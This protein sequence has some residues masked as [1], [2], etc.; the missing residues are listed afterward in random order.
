MPIN[1]QPDVIKKA[2]AAG[3][4][5][6]SEKPVAK[7][8]AT[9]KELIAWYRGL[10]NPPIWAVA[11]NFRYTESLV[12]AAEEVKKL[13]GKVVTFHLKRYGFVREND[14]YFNTECKLSRAFLGWG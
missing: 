12:R 6:L 11:E 14:K 2:I 3:K 4:H 9:A 10:S 1:N 7:D 5:V 8:V 13:G